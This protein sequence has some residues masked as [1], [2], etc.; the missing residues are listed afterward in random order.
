MRKLLFVLVS[1][2]SLATMNVAIAQYPATELL[3]P[4]IRRPSSSSAPWIPWLRR[5]SLHARD[6]TPLR[7]SVGATVGTNNAGDTG[8]VGECAIGFSEETCRRRG[9]KYRP[10]PPKLDSRLQASCAS[11]TVPNAFLKRGGVGARAMI[12]KL[13]LA[14]ATDAGAIAC[15][16]PAWTRSAMGDRCGAVR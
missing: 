5:P 4:R 3:R 14:T 11:R 13:A 15:R 8:F 10:T 1:T 12:L 2:G 16:C 9:Q 6:T 7:G